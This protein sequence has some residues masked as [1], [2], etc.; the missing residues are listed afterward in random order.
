MREEGKMEGGMK[1]KK[2]KW[3]MDGSKEKIK[4][5]REIKEIENIRKTYGGGE[6]WNKWKKK[7]KTKWKGKIGKQ[8]SRMEERK[9]LSLY[10][11][12]KY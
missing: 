10:L 5:D 2:E 11:I 6:K 9:R 7:W 12:P 4:S 8:R 1:G 3:W